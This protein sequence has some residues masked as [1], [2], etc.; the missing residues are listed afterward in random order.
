M[1]VGLGLSWISGRGPGVRGGVRSEGKRADLFGRRL[2]A[3]FEPPFYGNKVKVALYNTQCGLNV[4]GQV[5]R[6]DGSIIPNFYAGSGAAT[7]IS[8][9]GLEGYLPGNGLWASLGTGHAR[10]GARRRLS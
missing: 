10:R 2:P 9:T 4:N 1:A 6:P 3:P 8:G 5:L 7:G